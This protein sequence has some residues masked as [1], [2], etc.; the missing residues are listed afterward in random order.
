MERKW[1][2]A[3]LE[4][5]GH[6]GAV[7]R[8]ERGD[9]RAG[10]KREEEEF[11]ARTRTVVGRGGHDRR[12]I[13]FDHDAIRLAFGNDVE[14]AVVVEDQIAARSG[15]HNL[16]P[17]ENHDLAARR[18]SSRAAQRASRSL[19]LKPE[20][21]GQRE[22]GGP[23]R[24]RDAGKLAALFKA[25][26]TGSAEKELSGTQAQ[27]EFACRVGFDHVAGID[28]CAG[29]GGKAVS[30]RAARFGDGA[31]RSLIGSSGGV[32]RWDGAERGRQ[33]NGEAQAKERTYTPC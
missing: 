7:A 10:S 8:N 31:K 14:F 28:R 16:L 3:V 22:A 33:K 19:Q 30:M 13:L 9:T 32:G 6:A 15:D 24:Q 1:K 29:Q 11:A 25:D 4:Q 27:V 26:G 21:I 23:F 2:R 5:A 12:R 20:R 17:A 18:V